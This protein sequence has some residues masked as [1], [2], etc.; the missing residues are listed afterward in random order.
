M[1]FGLALIIIPPVI[2]GLFFYF[3]IKIWQKEDKEQ[4][5][6]QAYSAE[7]A[8]G[9]YRGKV[10]ANIGLITAHGYNTNTFRF[11]IRKGE[12]YNIERMDTQEGYFTVE[13]T[14]DF[15]IVLDANRVDKYFEKVVE[16]PK[17]VSAER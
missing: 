13:V 1:T 14:K 2:C 7:L 17:V 16:P 11:K 10:D 5:K 4:A 15:S 3:L 9:V 6:Q 8:D 12:L